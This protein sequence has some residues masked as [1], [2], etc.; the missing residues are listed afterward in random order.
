MV[1]AVTEL[2]EQQRNIYGSSSVRCPDLTV[3]DLLLLCLS[4]YYRSF[5]LAD[6]CPPTGYVSVG[7]V[8]SAMPLPSDYRL[9]K[10]AGGAE[11]P[12][13]SPGGATEPPAF[14]QQSA[15]PARGHQAGEEKQ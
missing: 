2:Q 9:S 14:L 1:T 8:E 13:L 5:S 4:S 10:D 6:L 15:L 7:S 11:H 3:D 12:P